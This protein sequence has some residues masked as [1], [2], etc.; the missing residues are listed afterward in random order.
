MSSKNFVL[1]IVI[2]SPIFAIKFTKLS[3]TIIPL[4]IFELFNSSKLPLVAKFI[5]DSS[6]Q[7]FM[8]SLFFATKS[9]SLLISIN[10]IFPPSFFAKAKPSDAVLLI[11]FDALAI[12]F[13]LKNSIDLSISPLFSS[14][15]SLQSLKPTPV[16]SLSLL[17]LS[18]KSLFDMD[19]NCKL[20]LFYFRS[21]FL[22]FVVRPFNK[23]FCIFNCIS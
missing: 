11:F 4:P 13:F 3:F 20:F 12:P 21:F 17:M 22:N 8:K 18:N 9:V 23:F 6:L 5:S 10:E 19:D 7:K 16:I 1:L 14:S 2:F 15:A